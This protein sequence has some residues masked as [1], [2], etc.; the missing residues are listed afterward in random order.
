M[1]KFLEANIGWILTLSAVFINFVV[2]WVRTT[3]KVKF[4]N[5][6][7][8]KQDRMLEEIKTTGSPSSRTAIM[9]LDGVVR[10]QADR[11]N[12]QSQRMGELEKVLSTVAVMA[13]DIDWIKKEMER[14]T[15]QRNRER[16]ER[17]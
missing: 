6:R 11:I 7:M 13:T 2:N 16:D 3:D 8:D 5:E 9:V 17:Q 12:L 14:E 1:D 4:L 15:K 10:S